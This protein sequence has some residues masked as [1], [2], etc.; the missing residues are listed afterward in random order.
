[1]KLEFGQQIV[2]TNLEYKI[3]WKSALWK[4]GYCESV[5]ISCEQFEG[6]DKANICIWKCFV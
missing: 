1:M 3:S 2:V 4:C 6:H 5:G